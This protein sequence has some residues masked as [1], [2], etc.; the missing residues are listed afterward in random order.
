MN[1]LL[2]KLIYPNIQSALRNQWKVNPPIEKYMKN[3]NP[4]KEYIQA[5]NRRNTNNQYN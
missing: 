4:K 3:M 5:I 1:K 2:F